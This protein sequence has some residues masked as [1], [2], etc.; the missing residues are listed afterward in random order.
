MNLNKHLPN[1]KRMFC[2]KCKGETNHSCKADHTKNDD[3]KPPLWNEYVY[4]L[5]VCKGCE[6]GTLETCYCDSSIS[7]TEGNR[8]YRSELAPFRTLY[9]HLQKQF[10]KLPEKLSQIYYESITAYNYQLDILCASGL[11]GLI[12]GICQD[13]KIQGKN[14]MIKIDGLEELI[15]KNIVKNLHGLRFMGNKAIHELDKTPGNELKLAIEICED[16]LNYI[17]ELEY[18]TE[19][20]SDNP[21]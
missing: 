12:E 8:D 14:L 7:K 19:K 2:N 18:K 15:P 3:L 9:F 16:L 13:K 11:R 5:W 17:Y 1:S 4:R 10:Y 20:L 6:Q 21:K